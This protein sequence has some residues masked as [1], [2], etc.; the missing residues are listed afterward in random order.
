MK[1]KYTLILA[2]ILVIVGIVGE[3]SQAHNIGPNWFRWYASDLAYV[4]F[5]ILV[6]FMV[7][8]WLIQL[9]RGEAI[10]SNKVK[11]FLYFGVI[12]A[13]FVGTFME[14]RQIS[15]TIIGHFDPW[16]IF[17]YFIGAALIFISMRLENME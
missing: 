12:V 11:M 7:P 10:D 9:V 15:G 4:P 6:W 17:V 5:S 14:Y 8:I 3:I 1:F 13:P 2:A 16:D